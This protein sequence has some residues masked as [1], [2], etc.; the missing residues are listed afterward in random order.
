MNKMIIRS[1]STDNII[2][3]KDKWKLKGLS[4][5]KNF[6]EE[7]INLT[8][9]FILPNKDYQAPEIRSKIFY[10]SRVDIWTIGAIFYMILFK[11]LPK[12]RT[13]SII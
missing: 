10:D 5:I 6:N 13:S 7:Q 9:T 12:I 2:Y 3:H 4:F 11:K 8:W 1:M